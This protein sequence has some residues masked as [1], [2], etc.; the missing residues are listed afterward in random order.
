MT[1]P[2]YTTVQQFK[3]FKVAGVKLSLNSYSDSELEVNLNIAE[4]IVES[5]VNTLFYEIEQSVYFN[6]SGT[7]VLFIAQVLNYPIISASTC[8]EVDENDTVLYTFTEGTEF[9]VQPWY[10]AKH[11][12]RQTARLGIGTGG[13]TWPKGA[14]NIKVTGTWGRSEVP[15]EVTRA[16]LLL[17]AE[18]CRPGSSGLAANNVAQQDWDDYKVQFKGQSQLPPNPGDSTGFDFID[19]LLDK[20]R[21]RPDLFLT[22]QTHIPSF[23]QYINVL[24][25]S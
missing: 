15:V 14:R 17:A 21:V 7:Q 1:T 16:T 25:M 6:G 13:P 18:I 12:M 11:W 22:P 5:Y 19:R 24:P 23:T 3:D 20:W 9:V 8:T 4:S 2:N 10:L